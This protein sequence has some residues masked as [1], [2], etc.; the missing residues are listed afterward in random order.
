M[1]GMSG[2]APHFP[3]PGRKDAYRV[4]P[5]ATPATSP[6]VVTRAEP[7]SDELAP[8]KPK[9]KLTRDEMRA[10]LAVEG[11]KR[12]PWRR[13]LRRSAILVPATIVAHILDIV[14]GSWSLA[15]MAV[16]FVAAFVWIA[17]PLFRRDDFT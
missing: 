5:L 8:P 13:S 1:E 4:T 7:P 10:L 16:A 9:P 17:R 3:P 6:K 2:D 12:P 14:L 11:A 15:I